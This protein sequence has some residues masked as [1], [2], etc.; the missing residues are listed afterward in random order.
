ML[1]TLAIVVITAAAFYFAL[2]DGLN[3][4]QVPTIV[5]LVEEEYFKPGRN[6]YQVRQDSED[7][8]FG[9]AISVTSYQDYE[10]VDD[11][12]PVGRFT[13]QYKINGGEDDGKTFRNIRFRRCLKDELN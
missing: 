2:I 3:E 4:H 11:S 5:K 8:P 7:E 9:F 10:F 1:F 6:V 12:S 13:M